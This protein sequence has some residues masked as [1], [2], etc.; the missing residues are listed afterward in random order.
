MEIMTALVAAG[1]LVVG[2]LVAVLVRYAV[3]RLLRRLL[4]DSARSTQQ[5]RSAARG[6]FVFMLV[7]AVA[8][9]VSVFAPS[10]FSDLPSRVLAF[11]PKAA[12]A[13][14]LLWAG[15][16]LAGVVEQLVTA[17]LERLGLSSPGVVAK[18]AYWL[19]MGLALLLAADQVG[20]ETQALQR[21]LIVVLAVVG[22]AAALALG[23]GGRT[24][25]GTVI[26]G[27][28]VEDRFAEGDR[29]AVE[30]YAGTI[31]EIGLASVSV[32][33]EGR[34]RIEIPHAW[35]LERP[36]RRLAGSSYGE[37]DGGADR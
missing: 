6:A 29:I 19:V 9:A 4:P 1:V 18:A 16:V 35:L 10:L 21:L 22:V 3:S 15:A 13:L 5:R 27:R 8:A 20:V 24:L 32:E 11:L 31:V 28:Y 14:V 34:D 2:V 23:I 37:G 17:S 12:V 33:T 30:E 7:L 26:A 36:V 25:A